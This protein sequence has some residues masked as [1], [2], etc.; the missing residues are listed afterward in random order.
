MDAIDLLLQRD[1]MQ[2]AKS[3]LKTL[4]DRYEIGRHLIDPWRVVLVGPPNVGKSSLLNRLLG[5]TRAIVHDQAGTTRDILAEQTSIDGW[6]IELIDGAGI[7]TASDAIEATGIAMTA[8]RVATAD[9]ALILVDPTVGWTTT[10]DEI[11]NLCTKKVLVVLTKSDLLG[12]ASYQFKFSDDRLEY[13][14]T[15]SLTGAGADELL[16]AIVHRLVPTALDRGAA[17]PFRKRHMEWI[18]SIV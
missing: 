7:R 14:A 17:V 13:V 15:S 5:Y 18:D 11:L 9:L 3:I 16:N 4:K 8:E 1:E 12:S 6:P 10:H 2:S